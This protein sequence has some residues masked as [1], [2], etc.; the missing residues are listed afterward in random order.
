MKAPPIIA[1]RYSDGLARRTAARA[2]DLH[3]RGQV[4]VTGGAREALLADGGQQ[5]ADIDLAGRAF[6]E[7]GGFRQGQEVI[8]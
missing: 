3:A 8:L 6:E 1:G 5:T 2:V 4:V 7:T